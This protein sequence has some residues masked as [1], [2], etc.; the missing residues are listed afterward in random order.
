MRPI[1][2][3][4]LSFKNSY[5][6]TMLISMRETMMGEQLCGGLEMAI[7]NPTLQSLPSFK[8]VLSDGMEE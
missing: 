7:L 4:C 8:A 2:V 3:T 6:D 1:M 5:Q